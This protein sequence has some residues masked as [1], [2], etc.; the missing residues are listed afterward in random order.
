MGYKG[1]EHQIT[2]ETASLGG[3]RVETTKPI[4]LFIQAFHNTLR[5]L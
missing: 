1:T 2:R 3:A 4:K 5:P